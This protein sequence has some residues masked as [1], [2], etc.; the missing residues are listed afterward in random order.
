LASRIDSYQFQGILG[1][2]AAGT[3][4]LAYQPELDR[5][6]AIKELSPTLVADPQFLERFRADAQVMLRLDSPNCVKVYDFIEEPGSAW[7]VSEYIEGASLRR[8][9]D[10]SGFLSPE[11]ALGVVKG[12][13]TGLA[14]GHWLGLLHRDVKPENVLANRE[15]VC[16]LSDFGQAL[17]FGQALL[18]AGPGAAG[19]IPAGAPN[20]ISPEQVTGAVVDYRSDIYSCGAM[21]FEF[22]TGKTPFLADNPLALMRMHVSEPVPDPRAVNSSLPQGVAEMVM[23]AMAKDPADRQPTA[24]QFLA[25]LEQAAV[26]GYGAHW[27]RRSSIKGLVAAIQAPGGG[28]LAGGTAGASGAGGGVGDGPPVTPPAGARWWRNKWLLAAAVAGVLLLLLAGLALAG[29]F[30]ERKGAPVPIAS[31]SPSPTES[32]SPSPEVS[33]SPSPLPSPSPSPSPSPTPKP[34]QSPAPQALVITDAVVYYRKC[35]G[36]G[37]CSGNLQSGASHADITRTVMID[38][39]AEHFE[40][41]EQYRYYYPGSVG[42]PQK[43]TLDWFG[44]LPQPPGG[45]NNGPQRQDEETVGPGSSGTHSAGGSKPWSDTAMVGLH[46]TG[47]VRFILSWQ[48]TPGGAPSQLFY[49]TCT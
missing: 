40:F 17:Y 32:P 29:V 2:G 13:V 42:S 4:K 33:P 38:C 15:G 34:S 16:K 25:D 18:G 26:A 44:E 11:Q 3:V 8:I 20:Y 39:A 7:L 36:A 43:I 9:L 10:R 30:G 1:S 48:P 45:S 6:V 22:L 21:L 19:G 23:R 24:F 31:P 28:P 41:A 46:G 47:I 27:E 49:Y 37:S 35:V 12:A 5:R 14:H